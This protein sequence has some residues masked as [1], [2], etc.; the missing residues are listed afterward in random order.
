MILPA[1]ICPACLFLLLCEREAPK[2]KPLSQN[3]YG[4]CQLPFHRGAGTRSVTERFSPSAPSCTTQRCSLQSVYHNTGKIQCFYRKM[5]KNRYKTVHSGKIW[6]SSA[7]PSCEDT[8]VKSGRVRQSPTVPVCRTRHGYRGVN[9][10]SHGQFQTSVHPWIFA[11]ICFL[12]FAR[13]VL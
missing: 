5:S 7:F 12:Y 6:H 11:A 13:F 1:G 10:I 2:A 3:P 8:V 9:F 4:F